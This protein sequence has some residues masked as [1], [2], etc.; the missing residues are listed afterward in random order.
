M[1]PIAILGTLLGIGR[2]RDHE[3]SRYS[4]SIYPDY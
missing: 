3:A 4:V 1:F 2:R